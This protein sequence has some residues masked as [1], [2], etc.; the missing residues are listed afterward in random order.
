[1]KSDKRLIRFICVLT[2]KIFIDILY[3]QRSGEV[4]NF[5]KKVEPMLI[6]YFKPS[7]ILTYLSVVSSGI[8]IYFAFNQ[9]IAAALICLVICGV[10][11]SF[12]GKVARACKRSNDEKL[13]GIQIDSLADMCAFIFL[14]TVIF[15]GMGYNSWYL[16]AVY[17]LYALN[18]VIRLAYFNVIAEESGKEKGVT[19]YHGLPVTSAAIIFPIFYLLKNVLSEPV[20]STLFISLMAF[21]SLLFIL[22]FT[23]RKPK[24]IWLYIFIVFAVIVSFLLF[25]LY[26]R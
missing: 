19:Y 13:F 17:I 2:S 9:R 14:P 16:V 10:L 5:K 3:K 4:L 24:N 23:F 1:M 26:I 11:D 22:N 7:V 6:G 12:D 21:V 25:M 18:G 20:F 8:G 15:Y